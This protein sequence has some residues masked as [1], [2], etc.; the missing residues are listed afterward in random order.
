VAVGALLVAPK[1]ASAQDDAA[2][3]EAYVDDYNQAVRSYYGQQAQSAAPEESQCAGYGR[4]YADARGAARTQRTQ[5]PSQQGD[6]A[7]LDYSGTR[8]TAPQHDA[9]D[10]ATGPTGLP[11]FGR[12][13]THADQSLGEADESARPSSSA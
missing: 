6:Y 9:V 7:D 1:A 4:A 3:Y 10:S 13:P 5:R 11:S 2:G 12:A 8:T